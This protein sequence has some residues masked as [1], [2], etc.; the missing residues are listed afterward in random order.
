MLKKRRGFFLILVLLMFLSVC[1]ASCSVK[2]AIQQKAQKEILVPGIDP[3]IAE[4]IRYNDALR[5]GSPILV[6]FFSPECHNCTAIEPLMDEIQDEWHGKVVVIILD[7][8]SKNVKAIANAANVNFIPTFRFIDR[9]GNTYRD[10]I[11]ANS[12]EVIV[13]ELKTISGS[14]RSEN[15]SKQLKAESQETKKDISPKA[16]SAK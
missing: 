1:L 2:P 4:I 8:T 13:R 11:G 7:V 3:E 12:K 15:N 5:E 10:L 16:G 14:T 6:Q 9:K